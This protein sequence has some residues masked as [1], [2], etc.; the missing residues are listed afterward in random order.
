MVGTGVWVGIGVRVTVAVAAPLGVAVR[1][2]VVGAVPG[3]PGSSRVRM[4]QKL[5]G[6]TLIF[7]VPPS[8]TCPTPIQVWGWAGW[9]TVL[10]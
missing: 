1:V 2:A 4:N 10:E 3:A 9:T 6:R 7:A 5:R 8:M